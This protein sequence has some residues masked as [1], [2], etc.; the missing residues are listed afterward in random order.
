MKQMTALLHIGRAPAEIMA[1]VRGQ[2]D[3][4][5]LDFLLTQQRHHT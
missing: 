1:L 2:G 5:G 3:R 4:K